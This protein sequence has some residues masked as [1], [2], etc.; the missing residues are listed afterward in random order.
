MGLTE[1]ELNLQPMAFNAPTSYNLR[2]R[3]LSQLRFEILELVLEVCCS[4][5]ARRVFIEEK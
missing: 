3:L 5:I 2:T 4:L 1:G